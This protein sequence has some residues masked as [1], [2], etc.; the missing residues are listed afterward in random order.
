[1]HALRCLSLDIIIV[2]FVL[3]DDDD[4]ATNYFTLCACMPGNNNMN[5]THNPSSF[6]DSSVVIGKSC[7]HND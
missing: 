1:M 4:D 7:M 3:D 5:D 6:A 2:I